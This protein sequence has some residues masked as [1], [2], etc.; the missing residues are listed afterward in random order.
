MPQLPILN[1]R[2][3]LPLAQYPLAG[4]GEFGGIQSAA[5]YEQGV[6]LQKINEAHD[7][8]TATQLLENRDEVYKQRHLDIQQNPDNYN[9]LR[10]QEF[11]KQWN[12][13]ARTDDR[14]VLDQMPISVRR[15][16]QIALSRLG[17]QAFDHGFQLYSK[18]YKDN[19]IGQYESQSDRLLK[20]IAGASDQESENFYKEQWMATIEANRH[21]GT[22]S[23]KKAEEDRIKGLATV[24][25]YRANAL[26]SD[27]QNDG[28][29]KFLGNYK[30]MFPNLEPQQITV[31]RESAIRQSKQDELKAQKDWD[32]M[33]RGT[34]Q[35]MERIAQTNPDSLRPEVVQ[36]ALNQNGIKPTDAQHIM[37]LLRNP[38]FAN[39]PQAI[40]QIL[41]DRNKSVPTM[42]S[43]AVA[44]QKLLQLDQHDP[45]VQ[46]TLNAI[47]NSDRL[48]QDRGKVGQVTEAVR[49]F[50]DAEYS[51]GVSV[52]KHFDTPGMQFQRGKFNDA[53][54]H[55][56][57]QIQN[58]VPRQKAIEDALKQVRPQVP[59]GRTKSQ[60]VQEY[61][62]E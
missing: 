7:M 2:A 21:A 60:Q 26:I 53:I 14:D 34:A 10:P 61:V 25:L 45:E 35:V 32:S 18:E 9:N 22:I 58:G 28:P 37:G 50:K 19:Q 29:N 15:H 51:P 5:A 1:N 24:D 48:L 44:R 52:L 6:A 30:T 4:P 38:T 56:E 20:D 27:S 16:A 41:Y 13:Q 46:R 3:N 62:G 31:L 42:Q 43:N 54:N 49:A 11:V 36:D 55:L 17:K 47:N 39:G 57:V 33:Q 23:G 59:S 40:N 8:Q 12:D